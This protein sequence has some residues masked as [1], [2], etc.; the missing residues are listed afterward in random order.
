MLCG[1][2]C[3][4][5]R[6]LK[7]NQKDKCFKERI[8][9]S[10]VDLN[11]LC[12]ANAQFSVTACAVFIAFN[13]HKCRRLSKGTCLLFSSVNVVIIVHQR[14]RSVLCILQS[15]ILLEVFGELSLEDENAEQKKSL[16]SNPRLQMVFSKAGEEE[17]GVQRMSK[18][19]KSSKS[20]MKLKID[21]LT[22]F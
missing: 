18:T 16:W 17:N 20:F 13:V 14:C 7:V 6:I 22:L 21:C 11:P 9:N 19:K 10:Y 8:P 4:N 12:C 1:G 5:S 3:S 15:L 2:K